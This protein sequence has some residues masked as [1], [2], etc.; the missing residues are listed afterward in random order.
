MIQCHPC[1]G[2][3][4]DN[5]GVATLCAQARGGHSP[6]TG[7]SAGGCAPVPAVCHFLQEESQL[8]FSSNSLFCS[9]AWRPQSKGSIGNELHA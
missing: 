4:L 7:S 1:Q 8:R 9:C 3:D 2:S 5:P 6:V